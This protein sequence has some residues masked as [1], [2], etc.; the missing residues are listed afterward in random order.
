[1]RQAWYETTG[2]AAE[3]LK[4]GIVPIPKPK[5]GEVLVRVYASGINPSDCKQRRGW[6]GKSPDGKVVPHSDGAGL[7][8][9]VGPDVDAALVGSRVWI[10][11]AR[12]GKFYGF[13]DG[14]DSG[15]ASE[16]VSLPVGHTAYLPDSVTFETGAA[17]GGP[18]CT[19]HHLIFGDGDVKGQVI[20]VQGGGGVVGALAIAFAARGGATVITTISSPEKEAI[21]LAAG[22]ALTI[23]YRQCNVAQ[24]VLERYPEGVDRIVEVDFAANIDTDSVLIRRDGIIASYSSP[25]NTVPQIPYYLLQFK[26][27]TVRFCQGA[28][29]PIEAQK[30]ALLAIDKGLRDGWIRPVIAATFPLDDIAQAHEFVENCTAAGKVVLT[31]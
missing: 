23:N 1:M 11:G 21:A 14:P 30:S 12:G 13:Q 10:W 17:L 24:A 27:V 18:A 3:V 16:Y 26:G 25:S 22:A 19:A 5:A 2:D 6:P 29:L 4:T 9:M 28:R 8:V 7:V 20:L 31:L 15:T